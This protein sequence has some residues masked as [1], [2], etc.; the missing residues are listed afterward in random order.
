[1]YDARLGHED[2][3]TKTHTKHKKFSCSEDI[4]TKQKLGHV[5]RWQDR[6]KVILTPPPPFTHIQL[7]PTAQIISWGKV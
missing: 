5:D 3:S 7:H 1:M 6:D 2:F 4:I